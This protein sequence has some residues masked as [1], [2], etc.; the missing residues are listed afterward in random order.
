M[1]R[2]SPERTLYFEHIQYPRPEGCEYDVSLG[3]TSFQIKHNLVFVMSA[4]GCGSK[5]HTYHY[6]KNRANSTGTL[7]VFDLLLPNDD[8]CIIQKCYDV[9]EE[10]SS[11][12]FMFTQKE[13]AESELVT[14]LRMKIAEQDML[15]KQL[16]NTNKE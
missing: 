2:G 13:D 7:I 14:N 9:V 12:D 3:H 1:Q 8:L 15:I 4:A 6:S 11:Q 5:S 10:R 16:Q